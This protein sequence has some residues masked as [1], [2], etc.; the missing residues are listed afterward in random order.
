MALST[1]G[2]LQVTAWDNRTV[3][4]RS[5]GM[6]GLVPSQVTGEKID[7]AHDLLGMVLAD[8][9]NTSHPLFTLE[10]I[11]IPLVVG[12]RNY[13]MPVGTNDLNRVF[14]RT[15]F[16]VTPALIA[17]GPNAWAYD[18]GA[19][20]PTIVYNWSILWLGTPVP[21]TFQSSPDN[22]NWTT[23]SATT[24][25]NFGGYGSQNIWYDMNVSAPQRYWR[26]IPTVVTPPNTLS[27]TSAALYNTPNDIEMYRFNKDDYYNMTNKG[28]EGRPLQ[29]YVNRDVAVGNQA[30]GCS[31]DLWPPADQTTVN[32]NGIMV[33]RRQRYIQDVGSLQQ[34]LEV[35]TRWFYTVLFMLADALS[36][37]TPEAKPD[38]IVAVQARLPQM[39][40]NLWLEERDRSPFKMNYNL[41]Q[42]TR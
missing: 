26:V 21:V 28:F 17:S 16:N 30:L 27:I 24:P 5:Y 2:T 6:L 20:N 7:I 36:F 35:P 4:D 29:Y 12:Q 19:N 9:V 33:A 42:Y 11:L 23:V 40:A 41:R 13:P 31:I 34:Q 32:L 39:K 14:F 1:T 38:R 8:A 15:S 3:Y 37:C 22:I 18:F 10:K 25:L